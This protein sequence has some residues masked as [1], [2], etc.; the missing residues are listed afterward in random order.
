MIELDKSTSKDTV[1]TYQ[2]P[3]NLFIF[4]EIDELKA[5]NG[6]FLFP[7]ELQ[8]QYKIQFSYKLPSDNEKI[9]FPCL[10]IVNLGPVYSATKGRQ[11]LT[12]CISKQ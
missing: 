7:V 10:A 6:L 4:P 2:I 3:D 1:L 11:I 8:N 9:S 12:S 5:I